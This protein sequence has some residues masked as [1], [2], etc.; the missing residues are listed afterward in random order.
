MEAEITQEERE[1]LMAEGYTD[2]STEFPPEV[3]EKQEVETEQ[4]EAPDPWA[5]VPSTVKAQIESLNSKLAALDQ[6]GGRVRQAES[7]IGNLFHLVESANKAAQAVEDAPSKSQIAAASQDPEKWKALKEDWPEWADALEGLEARVSG[8]IP[9]VSKLREEWE[10]SLSTRTTE[11]ERKMEE[12]I[13][14]IKHPDWKATATSD[15]FQAFKL[16]LPM[17]Y[18]EKLVSDRAEDAIEI[19]DLFAASKAAAHKQDK[20]AAN[21]QRLESSVETKRSPGPTPNKSEASMT[22]EELRRHLLSQGYKEG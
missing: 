5:G 19:L 2:T 15:E 7:R 18:A 22:P 17:Q 8:K 12:R 9:D 3:E 11:I 13:L 21:R 20:S 4:Q 6:L 1:Q 10:Q 14:T 16:S